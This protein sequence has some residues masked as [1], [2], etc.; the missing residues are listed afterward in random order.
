MHIAVIVVGKS[1]SYFTKVRGRDD[2][3]WGPDKN[4][5][6]EFSTKEEAL[7]AG[8]LSVPASIR[9]NIISEPA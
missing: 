8:Q 2:F 3:Y 9:Q 4:Q 5:A 6:H 1:R 7:K